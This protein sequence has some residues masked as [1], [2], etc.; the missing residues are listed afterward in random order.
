MEQDAIV[1]FES[2]ITLPIPRRIYKKILENFEHLGNYSI[3]YFANGSRMSNQSIQYKQV[4]KRTNVLKII[5]LEDKFLFLPLVRKSAIEYSVGLPQ[6]ISTVE[7]AIDRIII[8]ENTTNIYKVRISAECVLTKN[9]GQYYQITAE[10]EYAHNIS[11]YY[12]SIKAAEDYLLSI[13]MKKLKVY[14]E[15]IKTE[16]VFCFSNPKLISHV[17]SR[18]F[19]SFF[20]DYTKSKLEVK[21]HKFDGYKG[22]FYIQ[23]KVM[24][25]YDD[26]HTNI[27]S[28][29]KEFNGFENI[30]FQIE[31]LKGHVVI[32]DVLGGYIN[33]NIT[34]HSLYMPEPLD[35]ILF[36]MQLKK[37]GIFPDN[38]VVDL[39]ELGMCN[40]IVQYPIGSSTK[41]SELPFD[42]YLII[43]EDKIFKFKIPTIDVRIKNGYIQID[44]KPESISPQIYPNYDNNKIYEIAAEK[45]KNNSITFK[46]LRERLD[47]HYTSTA[48]EVSDFFQEINFIFQQ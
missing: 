40:A 23:N 25:I 47:R 26:L 3:F 45:N 6:P 18:K 36:F 15:N 41:E 20:K 9:N 13:F 43:K 17:P 10:I 5:I 31:I 37:F 39:K 48:K 28:S 33:D 22:R 32:T 14:V 8:F 19:N 46:V 21:V 4:K 11:Y 44:D 24:Y 27:V 1:E 30:F 2:S 35:V 12:N 16:H 42:G 7:T 38:V 29:F 34:S